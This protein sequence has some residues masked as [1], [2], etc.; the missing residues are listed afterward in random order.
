M[1]IN[2][3]VF[4]CFDGRTLSFFLRDGTVD[5]NAIQSVI[6]HDEYDFKYLNLEKGSTIIDIGAYNGGEAV[7]FG[8]LPLNLKIY[9][10][11]PL[12]EN[13]GM[14]KMNLKQNNCNVNVFQMAVGGKNGKI[15]MFYGDTVHKFIGNYNS[16]GKDLAEVKMISLEQIFKD[17]HIEHCDLLKVD[18]EGGEKE[19]FENCPR[20]I[21]E[22][23]DLIIGER[24]NISEED[25]LKLTKGVFVT[26]DCSY[27]ELSSHLG[28]FKF[29][30]KKL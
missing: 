14:I 7:Y 16:C 6:V 10:Y 12:P 9:S 29:R 15:K 8:S 27:R 11:E 19:M 4:R 22:K 18:S 21:L 13:V 28:H 17:N 20:E 3:G 5:F 23:I 26:K 2:L 25:L 24:H 30:N 1:K